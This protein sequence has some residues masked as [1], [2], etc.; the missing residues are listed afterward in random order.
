[1]RHL[2]LLGGSTGVGKSTTIKLLETRLAKTGFLDVDNVWRTTP[3]LV[4]PKRR[5]QAH[6][7]VI[8]TTR[9]YYGAGCETV[10]ISWVFARSQLYQPILDAFSSEVDKITQL[11]LVAEAREL[12]RRV[13]ARFEAQGSDGDIQQ[14]ISFAMSRSK[15]I[16]SLQFPKIDVT[17][18]DLA[19]MA[20]Q[21]A[22]TI[23]AEKA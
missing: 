22:T 6:K 23:L 4:G 17:S 14:R 20:D 19:E 11:Y 21:V 2:V 15:M 9:R 1:M 10:V 7:Q 13:T 3:D 8:E 18:L 12:V 16:E 5:E